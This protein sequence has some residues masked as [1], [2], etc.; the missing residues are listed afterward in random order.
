MSNEEKEQ[1]A[2]AVE[3]YKVEKNVN[4][5]DLAKKAKLNAAMITHVLGR[6]FDNY[7]NGTPIPES[8]FASLAKAMSLG[9]DVVETDSYR[10]IMGKLAELK[11]WSLAG[12]I[13]GNTGAGK[14]FA[15]NSFISKYPIGT[16]KITAAADFTPK[17]FV[18]VLGSLL[19][20]GIY[21][22]QYDLREHIQ[23][24]LS[25]VKNPIIIVDEAENLTDHN[26]STIKA[27]YDA[28]EGQCAIVLV[29]ANN[30]WSNLQAKARRNR[31]RAHCF[32]QIVSR[33]RAQVLHVPGMNLRDVAAAANQFGITDKA[34]I[35]ALHQK[36]PDFRA[37]FGELQHNQ[38]M[39][40]LEVANG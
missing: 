28:L 20:L 12:V 32:P 37:L 14:T 16:Y 39:A 38:R 2:L 10:S 25:E 11:H 1:I 3:R 33:F 19:G 21:E 8:V 18:Q 17:K 13:D 29:G 24:K 36:S 22:S 7:S 31:L 30:Y 4:N 35:N 27:I 5:A 6:K 34:Q 40:E 15:I 9:V 23:A 26:Y